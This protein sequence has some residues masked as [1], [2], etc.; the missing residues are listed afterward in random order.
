MIKLILT[1]IALTSPIIALAQQEAEHAKKPL[2]GISC[3][4]PGNNS[5]TRLTYSNSV[6]RTGGTPMLIPITT[7]SIVLNDILNRID[8]IIMI[9]GEDIH[10]SYYGEEPI[11]QL[12][13]VDS[14]RD[15]Y[16]I[17]LIKMAH[18][19]N[20]PMLGICRGEQLINVA[21]GGNL[22]QDIPTQHPDTTV[23]H[24][25]K[26]PSSVPTHLVRFEAG[27]S[28]A[29][30]V[31]LS[32]MMTNTHHHQ[33]VKEAAPGFKI[34]AWSTDSIPEAIESTQEYPIWGLQFHPEALTVEG[35]GVSARFFQFLIKKAD[36]YRKAKAIQGTLE[37]T[38]IDASQFGTI[39][40]KNVKKSVKEMNRKGITIDISQA[41]DKSIGDILKYTKRPVVASKYADDKL[42]QAVAQNGGLTIININDICASQGITKLSE[43]ANALSAIIGKAGID[44]VGFNP[45]L[46]GA[47]LMGC[48][49]NSDHLSISM[50]LLE[51]GYSENDIAKLWQGNLH[52]VINENKQ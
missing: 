37:I 5:T 7:D 19:K 3:S 52:R 29:N 4:H 15:I 34:S 47:K 11:P 49:G 23:N 48:N 25:Q 39:S 14:I 31:G 20:I 32:E 36:I 21:F 16:D 18:S 26:E 27:S 2:I 8:G 50:A 9:G 42:L 13:S 43:L 28:I 45:N 46:N 17:A 12:G 6:I 38:S 44:H 10:P 1:I 41:T 24:R 35:D 30:I 51:H 22:Y 33:A 40:E